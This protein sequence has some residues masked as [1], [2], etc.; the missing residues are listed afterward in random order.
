MGEPTHGGAIILVPVDFE[1]ASLNA[2]ALAKEL[3]P[4]GLRLH[5]LQRNSQACAFDERH[6]FA[7]VSFGIGRVGLPN[8]QYGWTPSAAAGA[9]R[10]PR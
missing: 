10:S 7:P 1:E 8:V 2:L 6:G 4:V 5:T 9:D 3:A